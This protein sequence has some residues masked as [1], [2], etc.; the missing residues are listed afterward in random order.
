MTHKNLL[1]ALNTID[2]YYQTKLT[3]EERMI[4]T[5]IYEYNLRDIQD[6]IAMEALMCTFAHC[7][8]Y[9]QMLP[10]WCA[11]IQKIKAE[12]HYERLT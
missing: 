6:D 10:E 11:E 9:Y 1:T 4:R 8:S 7:R 2:A 12:V 5:K 3:D